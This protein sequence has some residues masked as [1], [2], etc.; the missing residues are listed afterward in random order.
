[1]AVLHRLDP[2]DHVAGSNQEPRALI[3]RQSHKRYIC[4][5][6]PRRMSQQVGSTYSAGRCQM[7]IAVWSSFTFRDAGSVAS[8]AAIGRQRAAVAPGRAPHDRPQQS[9]PGSGA[10]SSTAA[11][12]PAQRAPISLP[13][14]GALRAGSKHFELGDPM[15]FTD[16]STSGWPQRL[17]DRHAPRP[18]V[19]AAGAWARSV[20]RRAGSG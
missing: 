16:V 5:H 14:A 18:A 1:M 10:S 15:P 9:V 12:S 8:W 2:L 19:L 20:P 11:S 4:A 6:R 13:G 17:G 7:V 3:E